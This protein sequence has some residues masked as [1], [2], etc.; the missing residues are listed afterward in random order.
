MSLFNIVNSL[1]L[2]DDSDDA[3]P[4]DEV[5]PGADSSA[6]V[7]IPAKPLRLPA[8][9]SAESTWIPGLENRTVVMLA[10]AAIVVMVAA[11][12]KKGERK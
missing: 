9:A 11:S 4:G 3:M 7:V 8:A 2:T 5:L 12:E 1:F 10:A 6:P